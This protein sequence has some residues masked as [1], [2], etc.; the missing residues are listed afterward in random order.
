M[1]LRLFQTLCG[2]RLPRLR[3]RLYL[4]PV[5]VAPVLLLDPKRTIPVFDQKQTNACTGFV[6]AEQMD[7]WGSP[8][9]L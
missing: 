5:V 4:P 1:A 9:M 3:D 6:L 8:F 2:S 7:C